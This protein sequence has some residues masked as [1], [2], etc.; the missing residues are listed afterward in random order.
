MVDE[1]TAVDGILLRDDAF[2]KLDI[3]RITYVN[4]QVGDLHML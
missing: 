2:Q 1:L 4:L 3:L